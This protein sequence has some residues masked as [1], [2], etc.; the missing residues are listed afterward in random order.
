MTKR[1]YLQAGTRCE[2][3]RVVRMGI[4]AAGQQGQAVLPG[5]RPGSDVLGNDPCRVPTLPP[6]H[7]GVRHPST[8]W[9]IGPPWRR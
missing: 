8:V 6:A 1:R 4:A 5:E 9:P 3:R 7:R 2:Q